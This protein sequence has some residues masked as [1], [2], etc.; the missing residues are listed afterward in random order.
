MALTDSPGALRARAR[1]KPKSS[2]GPAPRSTPPVLGDVKGLLGAITVGTATNWPGGGF[3][4]ET[5]I[6]YA[7]AGNTPGVR[8]LVATP[9]KFSDIRYI[10]G[11]AGRPMVEVWGP[12]DCCA[13]D[14]GFRTREDLPATPG[15]KPPAAGGQAAPPDDRAA[16]LDIQ[17]LP[18][19]KPP[20]GI[21]AAIDLDRGELLFQV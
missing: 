12:G 7:P 11:V 9:P 17:G 1:E 6:L 18:I 15:A 21:L 5:H 4:P 19:V 14:S 10:T 20:Y 2:R 13:A 16:G 3:D 8:S